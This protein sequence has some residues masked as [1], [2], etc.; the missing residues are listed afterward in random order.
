MDDVILCFKD[1]AEQ[2]YVSS[3]RYD[4]LNK[5][6]QSSNKME[7]AL[8]IAENKDRIHLRNTEYQW[9]RSLEYAGEI[10]DAV[11]KFE[12]ANTHRYDVPRLLIE[13]PK[14]LEAYIS[15]S[16]DSEL[17]K[18][19]GQYVESQG[20]MGPALKYYQQANDV[21]SQVRV[22]CFLGEEAKAAEIAR[23]GSD[24]AAC[25]HMARHYETNGDM[26]AAVGF[27][28]KA[29][30][31][32]NAVRL[33]KEHGLTEELWNIGMVA[34]KR[35]KIECAKYLEHDQPNKAVLLYQR[36]GKYCLTCSAGRGGIYI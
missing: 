35:E 28:I 13:H 4:L 31:Y 23:I 9:A 6:H 29:N 25:Y 33:C 30:A 2:L 36:A 19:W 15:K 5:L 22:L 18:W 26:D 24:K 3:A 14:D 17:L 21:Y 34:G 7:S 10:S 20:D 12:Q 1:E 27:F 11:N 8:T 16:G 32:S